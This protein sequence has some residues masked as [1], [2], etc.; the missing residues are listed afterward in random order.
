MFKAHKRE[1]GRPDVLSWLV[2]A[3]AVAVAVRVVRRVIRG[4][5]RR[6]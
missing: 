6:R 3:V 4:I 1:H 5:T 2:E